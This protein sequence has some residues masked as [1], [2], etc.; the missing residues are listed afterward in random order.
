MDIFTLIIS[1]ALSN[2]EFIKELFFFFLAAFLLRK[3][4]NRALSVVTQK[5]EDM[6]KSMNDL[7]HTLQEHIVQTGLKMEA[8]DQ[9]FASFSADIE[10]IKTHL[11]MN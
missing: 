4:F 2:P 6:S 11:G 8:G 10:K 1:T 9:K 5:L 3:G 7:N